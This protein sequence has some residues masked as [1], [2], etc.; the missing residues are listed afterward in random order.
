MV[1]QNLVDSAKHFEQITFLRIPAAFTDV[2]FH[3]KCDF[4]I[5]SKVPKDDFF[6]CTL[7]VTFQFDS[8]L[9]KMGFT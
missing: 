2:R 5:L 7:N 1:L 8:K 4:S 3:F 9:Q 6:S